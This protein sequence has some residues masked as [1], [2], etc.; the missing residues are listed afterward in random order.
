MDA[1]PKEGVK[2]PAILGNLENQLASDL[3]GMGHPHVVDT[4]RTEGDS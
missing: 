2:E 3:V 1:R 4:Q